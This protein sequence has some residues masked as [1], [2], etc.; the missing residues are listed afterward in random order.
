MSQDKSAAPHHT[1]GSVALW[2]GAIVMVLIVILFGG[3]GLTQQPKS[4]LSAQQG[5]AVAK[6]SSKSSSDSNSTSSS[7][8]NSDSNADSGTASDDGAAAADKNNAAQP[9]IISEVAADD[10]YGK[11]LHHAEIVVAGYGTIELELNANAAPITTANF[12]HLVKQGFYDGLTFH[13]VIADFMIQGGDPN[14]DGTGGAAAN[15]KGEFSANGVKNVIPHTRGTISM[16]RSQDMD[17][18]SSQFFIMQKTTPSLDGQY[19]AFGH[20][21][22]GMDVVDAICEKTTVQ[23]SNGSVAPDDQ[24]KIEKITLID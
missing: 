17:S 8:S 10:P 13:R 11:G 16:S 15:I 21:T 4:S 5:S 23:D 6:E 7:D 2:V 3:Y 20:V 19:A 9:A 18:A 24:P 14:A 22:S 1:K 12:C